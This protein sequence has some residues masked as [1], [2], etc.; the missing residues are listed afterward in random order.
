[1]TGRSPRRDELTAGEGESADCDAH[2]ELSAG[3]QLSTRL[4]VSLTASCNFG[5]FFCHN[6]GQA[7]RRDVS[8]SFSIPEYARI[9][10]AAVD[11]GITQVKLTGGEPLIYRDDNR[12]IA[13]LVEALSSLPN[14]DQFELSMTTNGSLLPRYASRLRDSGLDRVTVSIHA[15]SPAAFS[16]FIAKTPSSRF[17]SASKALSALNDA[18]FVNT[19][20]NTVV[21]GD[22]PAGN[23]EDLPTLVQLVRDSKVDEHRFY[24]VIDADTNGV[25]ASWVRYWDDGLASIVAEYLA[26]NP[27]D[28]REIAA[29]IAGYSARWSSIIL[30]RAVL[31]IQ[32]ADMRYAFEAMR[33][34]RLKS[35]AISDEGP[36]ALRLSSEGVLVGFLG[37]LL[38][39]KTH[40]GVERPTIDPSAPPTSIQSMFSTVRRSFELLSSQTVVGVGAER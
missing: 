40:N 10:E 39:E 2:V 5:C 27:Q 14:R 33:P 29:A 20:V 38:S 24:T 11:A 3:A 21:F 25:D 6:E 19:K 16:A 22:G 35:R 8:P 23:L 4:R 36:Y 26:P 30:P 34:G 1:M 9:I 37:D 32:L 31:K 28:R 12:T 7:H 15:A 13:H 17:F 18:G